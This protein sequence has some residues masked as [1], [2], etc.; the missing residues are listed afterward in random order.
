MEV[1]HQCFLHAQAEFPSL[2]GRQSGAPTKC[3]TL[4]SSPKAQ[5]CFLSSL[6][7]LGAEGTLPALGLARSGPLSADATP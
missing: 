6:S 5:A 4:Q 1:I 7:F 2:P 3:S